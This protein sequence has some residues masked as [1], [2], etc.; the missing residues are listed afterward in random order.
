MSNTDK[1]GRLR[2]KKRKAETGLRAIGA[3]PRG[4]DY[5][6]GVENYASVHAHSFRHTG[7]RGWYWV[8]RAGGLFVNACNIEGLSE[9][10]AKAQAQAQAHVK[11]AIAAK[12]KP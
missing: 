11:A 4:S 5:T 12:D 3:G 1:R 10:Q 9:D 7:K 8:S 2:W 6:D